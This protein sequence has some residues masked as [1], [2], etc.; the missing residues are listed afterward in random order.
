MT[1]RGSRSIRTALSPIVTS[2]QLLRL[3]DIHSP[4]Q[5]IIERQVNHLRRLVDDL[6][7]VSRI[8][9]G[10]I[11]LRRERTEV[12]A[13]LAAAIETSSPLFEQRRHRIEVDVPETGLAVD[14]DPDRMAQVFSNLMTN[15]VKYSEPG[16][17]IAIDARRDGDRVRV[18][19]IDEGAGIAADMIDKV[20]DM[21][22]QQPQTLERSRGGLGLGLSIVK[23]LVELHG[24]MV[25]AHSVGVGHGTEL[26]VELPAAGEAE[27]PQLAPEPLPIG[28]GAVRRI[29]VVDDNDDAALS[30]KK[31]LER[32]GYA[33]AIAHDGPAALRAAAVFEPEIA[34]LDIGL[35]VMDGYE[36][37]R[38]LRALRPLHLVAL[39]G[40]GQEAD[41]RRSAEAGFEVHLTKPVDLRYLETVV[42]SLD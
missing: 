24:G 33:V 36:L 11:E 14:A 17:R 28:G 22:V 38:R 13:V 19:V 21:F 1:G 23:R 18:R 26:V 29:L 6:L 5:D 34:L 8:A 7:D 2:L 27:R 30:L 39:S 15:A 37:A 9:R 25:W 12:A 16:T 35:P 41:R 10:K 42:R 4:E 32:L 3:R 40:Y 20:F 31:A